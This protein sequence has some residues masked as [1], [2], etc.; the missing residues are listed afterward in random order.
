MIL[1]PNLFDSFYLSLELC[2]ISLER[3]Y[4]F[5]VIF[6][7]LFSLK[8]LVAKTQ[9]LI[10]QLFIQIRFLLEEQGLLQTTLLRGKSV[11]LKESNFLFIHF[12]SAFSDF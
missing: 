3:V 12:F 8:P 10:L 1:G 11:S 2:T 7:D 9:Q 6:D 5:A 4:K